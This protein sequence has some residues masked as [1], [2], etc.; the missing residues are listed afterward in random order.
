MVS[1]QLLFFIKFESEN[2]LKSKNK[3]DDFI[4]KFKKKYNL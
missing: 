2:N 3:Y 4:I 1:Y